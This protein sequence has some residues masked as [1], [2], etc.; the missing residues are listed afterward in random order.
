MRALCSS[1]LPLHTIFPPQSKPGVRAASRKPGTSPSSKAY[2]YLKCHRWMQNNRHELKHELV[3][4]A[5]RRGFLKGAHRS[6][7]LS[8]YVQI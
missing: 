3:P 2:S 4:S 8:S 5:L 1:L 6:S 7:L